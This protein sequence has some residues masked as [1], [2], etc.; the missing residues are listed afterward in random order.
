[1]GS[2]SNTG[3]SRDAARGVEALRRQSDG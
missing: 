3:K 2:K 1:V